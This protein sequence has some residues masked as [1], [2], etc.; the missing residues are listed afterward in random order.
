MLAPKTHCRGCEKR[1]PG[2]HG[3]CEDY[4]AA[5]AECEAGKEKERRDKDREAD[6]FRRIVEAEKRSGRWRRKT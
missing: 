5:R 3:K 4:Q 6:Q 1:Y 2:C